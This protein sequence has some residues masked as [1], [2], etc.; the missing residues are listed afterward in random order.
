MQEK[1]GFIKVS[2]IIVGGPAYRGGKLKANDIIL[3]VQQE[4]GEAVDIVDM[5][6]DKAV[7]LIRGKKGTKV[8]LNVKKP[9]G[10]IEDITIT[11]DI[12]IIE[13]TYAQSAVINN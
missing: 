1:D 6:L 12:V 8:T 4:G 9:D 5:R 2:A 13:E 10:G 3:K 7:Q 11:R